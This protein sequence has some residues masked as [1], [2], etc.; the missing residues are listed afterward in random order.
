VAKLA[1]ALIALGAAGFLAYVVYKDFKAFRSDYQARV[2]QPTGDI[3]NDAHAYPFA[4][5]PEGRRRK[6][7]WAWMISVFARLVGRKARTQMPMPRR[8]T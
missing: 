4:F 2:A 3:G 6:S 1:P 5:S 7:W 8:L